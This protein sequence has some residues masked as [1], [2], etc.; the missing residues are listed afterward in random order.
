MSRANDERPVC[1]LVGSV[2]ALEQTILRS[3]Y[4]QTVTKLGSG[5]QASLAKLE[6]FWVNL[7]QTTGGE[8]PLAIKHIEEVDAW[9]RTLVTTHYPGDVVLLDGY[10]FITNP[11]GS[12][13]QPWHL[14]YNADY[15][16]LFIPMTPLTPGNCFQ[17]LELPSSLPQEKYAAATADPDRVD[18]EAL[19]DSAEWVSV[20]QLIARPFSIIRLNFG[21]IHRGISNSESFP[22]VVF[23]V[24][25]KKPGP[26]L[27]K[28]P[29]VE[30]I[31]KL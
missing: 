27:P 22:R 7:C 6:V 28:E 16:T 5:Y 14:D 29:L 30:V 19:V 9:A 1:Q 25:V 2:Q 24:S 10:G 8:P 21:A 20:R 11:I 3:I 13:T 17:Y 23:W 31:R 4:E 18:F 15:S 12:K 26:P